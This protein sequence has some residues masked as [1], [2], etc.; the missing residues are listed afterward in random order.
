MTFILNNALIT[1]NIGLMFWTLLTFII[2]LVLLSKFAWKPI[3]NGI[4]SREVSIENALAEA[5]KAR[6]EMKNLKSENE[7]LLAEARGERDR[8][9]KEAREIREKMVADAKGMA[10]EEARLIVSNAKESIEK[11]KLAAMKELREQVVDLALQAASKIL[12][13]ELDN[14]GA[15][16]QLVE[17]YLNDVKA[18]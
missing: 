16:E 3:M 1:P 4:R 18:S 14:R 7:S 10:H 8:I 6:E 12:K 5:K 2:L 9:L 15:Q 13:K 11:E 17:A